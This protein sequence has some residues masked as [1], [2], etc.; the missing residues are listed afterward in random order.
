MRIEFLSFDLV[1]VVG[2]SEIPQAAYSD[3]RV[4]DIL[5]LDQKIEDPIIVRIGEEPFFRGRPGLSE[6]H[7]A[8]RIDE[9]IHSR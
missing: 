6:T 3:L 5:L 1:A 8:V 9:R 2:K 7:K 4:G